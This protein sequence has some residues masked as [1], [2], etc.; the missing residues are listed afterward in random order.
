[1]ITNDEIRAALEQVVSRAPDPSRIQ[2]RLAGGA[3]APAASGAARGRWCA[4]GCRRVWCAGRAAVAKPHRL[5]PFP[6]ARRR[7]CA[8]RRRCPHDPDLAAVVAEPA[9][10]PGNLRGPLRYRPTWLPDGFVETS[11]EVSL[12]GGAADYQ[13]RQ[14]MLAENLAVAPDKSGES[15]PFL[16]LMLVPATDLPMGDW[17]LAVRIN[18]IE[19]GLSPKEGQ[20]PQVIWPVGDGLNLAVM[21]QG[22]GDDSIV[23]QWLARSVEPDG[24][25][26]VECPLDFGWLPESVQGTHHIAM[27]YPAE[28]W[29]ANLSVLRDR[30]EIVAA[31]L[32]PGVTPPTADGQP[33]SVRGQPGLVHFYDNG[34]GWAYAELEHGLRLTVQLMTRVTRDDLLQIIAEL[35]VGPAPYLGWLGKR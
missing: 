5:V 1:M 28:T 27:S 9:A 31:T 29:T 2:A 3:G 11:R 16:R 10:A 30:H 35:K 12:R 13:V 26:G 8:H 21:V 6:R 17:R 4:G 20:I 25:A 14:W 34:A 23:A 22:V 24:V 19:G 32:G 18:G 7:R 15:P 33:E